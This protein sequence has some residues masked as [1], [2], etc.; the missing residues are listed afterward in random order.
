MTLTTL[1]LLPVKSPQENT[2]KP[3]GRY[4]S[5]AERLSKTTFLATITHVTNYDGEVMTPEEFYVANNHTWEQAKYRQNVAV[6]RTYC[7]IGDT[8]LTL[9]EFETMHPHIE[10][11]S[12]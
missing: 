7:T 1:E 11:A 2:S 4:M 5:Y 12:D 8:A 10:L 3:A 6:Q 9:A